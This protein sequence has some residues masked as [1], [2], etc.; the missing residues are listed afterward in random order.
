MTLL[1]QR[2]M[3]T[4][5]GWRSVLRFDP[6]DSPRV[7]TAAEALAK[8]GVVWWRVV[9]DDHRQRVLAVYD[10]RRWQAVA[11]ANTASG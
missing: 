8:A 2:Q 3:P 7:Q 5:D 10:G 9:E 11:E 1:L 6:A 4:S